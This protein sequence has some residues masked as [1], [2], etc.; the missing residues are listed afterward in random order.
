ML[1]IL[2]ICNGIYQ[3]DLNKSAKKS[4]YADS[5]Q[6]HVCIQL[7]K[8]LYSRDLART[9]AH[10]NAIHTHKNEGLNDAVY[11]KGNIVHY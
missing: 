8:L 3:L 4:T 6:I 9:L 2:N 10:S 11:L 1:C 7:C 5:V